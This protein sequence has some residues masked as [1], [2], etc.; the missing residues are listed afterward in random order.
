MKRL[1]YLLINCLITVSLSLIL[2]QGE[3]V[4]FGDSG[5]VVVVEADDKE[6]ETTDS[7]WTY[8]FPDE[9]FSYIPSLPKF[10][11]FPL[12]PWAGGGNGGGEI[13]PCQ[14]AQAKLDDLYN[15]LNDITEQWVP[16]LEEQAPLNYEGKAYK[17]N[18]SGWIRA[19]HRLLAERDRITEEIE[20]AH[21][22]KDAACAN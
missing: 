3:P 14:D 13:D 20:Q 12:P 1:M 9:F 10:P 11:D 2:A 19:F 22:Q 21:A 4:D 18:T 5:I 16:A 6:G 8:W 15:Q 7:G 17:A